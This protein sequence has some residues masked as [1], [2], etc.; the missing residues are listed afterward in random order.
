MIFSC[1]S[2]KNYYSRYSLCF[3][4]HLTNDKNDGWIYSFFLFSILSVII[5]VTICFL[6][7]KISS[8]ILKSGKI[9]SKENKER[10]I[11]RFLKANVL[12]IVSNLMTWIP[13]SIFG[14]NQFFFAK[15]FLIFFL[16]F[17]RNYGCI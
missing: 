14:I 9:L 2:L 12:I 10:R 11:Q 4:L 17:I 6:Y 13:I 7:Y 5:Y 16:I 8:I 3:S 15:I 1:H